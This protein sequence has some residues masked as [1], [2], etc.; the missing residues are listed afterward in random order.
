MKGTLSLPGPQWAPS[1]G[2]IIAGFLLLQKTETQPMA[3][4]IAQ[5]PLKPSIYIFFLS[6]ELFLHPV[7]AH[8]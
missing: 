2:R 6:K 4:R 3:Q 5:N 8:T 1:S 7:S